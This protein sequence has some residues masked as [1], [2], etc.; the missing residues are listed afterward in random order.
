MPQRK[1]VLEAL[2]LT[3]GTCAIVVLMAPFAR[4]I[5]GVFDAALSGV[6]TGLTKGADE[7]RAAVMPAIS[8]VMI[9]SGALGAIILLTNLLLTGFNASLKS[10]EPKLS[11]L[12]PINGL[13]QMFSVAILYSFG[14]LITYFTIASI[15]LWFLVRASIG[16]AIDAAS[17]GLVCLA[18][19]FPPMFLK[20]AAILLATL[21]IMA[22]IDY[23]IQ[24][25]LWRSQL[26]MS[27]E[28]IKREYKSSEG[29][30]RVK[31]ARKNIA[32][33]DA[34]MPM[35]RD[36][37]HVV[38]AQGVMVA[39]VYRPGHVPFM[40]AKVQGTT[41]PKLVRKYRT[42]GAKCVN[43]PKIAQEFYA[44]AAPGN[45]LRHQSAKGM[46]QVLRAA[47]EA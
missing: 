37:T 28:D 24:D 21:I 6:Q 22:V 27:L 47:G 17:C 23:K 33:S 35:M 46:S 34:H 12:D 13:K 36:V 3:L 8:L 38:Y 39:L 32:Q 26:K 20:A 25:V 7:M 2:L 29:D 1:N 11:K 15:T 14:R 5:G 19:L 43:L 41:V 30:P 16:D 9:V 40:A 10:L 4:M 31:G 42:I 18:A 45:Y 44:M